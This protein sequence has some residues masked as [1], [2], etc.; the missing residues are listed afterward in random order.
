LRNYL[1]NPT[2]Q[3]GL[4]VLTLGAALGIFSLYSFFHSV[5]KAAWTMSP[6]LFPMLIALFSIGLGLCL[7][8]EGK[9]QVDRETASGTPAPAPEAIQTKNVLRVAEMSA[10]YC[11]LLPILTFVPA[12]ALFLYALMSFLGET[13]WKVRLPLAILVPLALYAMFSLGLNVRLP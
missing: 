2:V 4:A 10:A 5:V 1:S 9:G 6:Y 13:R 7:F 12:T 8:R 11:F 3:D